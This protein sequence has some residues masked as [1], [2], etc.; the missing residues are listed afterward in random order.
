MQSDS[1]TRTVDK[2]I[3]EGGGGGTKGAKIKSTIE[4]RETRNI[5]TL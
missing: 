1:D 3:G 5:K 2:R 4:N